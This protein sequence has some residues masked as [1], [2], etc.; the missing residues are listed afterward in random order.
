MA[1][2]AAWNT[3]F[4]SSV[5][6]AGR[7]MAGVRAS[8]YAVGQVDLRDGAKPFGRVP[9]RDFGDDADEAAREGDDDQED[10]GAR[11]D[12][13]AV[14]AGTG[15]RRWGGLGHRSVLRHCDLR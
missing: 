15:L 9:A 6:M 10:R 14:T 3:L 8:E 2:L 5:A 7:S 13:R 4:G 11:E 1:R 12:R